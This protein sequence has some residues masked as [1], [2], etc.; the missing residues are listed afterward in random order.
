MERPPELERLHADE[1]SRLELSPDKPKQEES[2]S[3][4]V[5][6]IQPIESKPTPAIVASIPTLNL[7]VGKG[8]CGEESEKSRFYLRHLQL[9]L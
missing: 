6:P 2:S 7:S 3:R 5:S 1:K 4:P 9:F 8:K